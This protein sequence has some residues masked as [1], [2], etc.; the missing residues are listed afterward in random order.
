MDSLNYYDIN[1]EGESAYTAKIGWQLGFSQEMYNFGYIE[2]FKTAADELVEQPMP[3][4]YVYPIMFSY[5]QFIELSL[6]NI[7]CKYLSQDEYIKFIKKSSH[8]LVSIWKEAKKL[9][10]QYEKFDE[11]HLNFIGK[12]VL[13]INSLDPAS[14]NFRY[15][16][17]KKMNNSLEK[18]YDINGSGQIKSLVI[19][20]YAVKKNVDEYDRMIHHTYDD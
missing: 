5:R 9:L 12:L 14:F 6:K 8:N 20:L 7:C 16:Q 17:D 11:R 2:S 18:F 19:N 3:D 10:S 15:P 1:A 4:L 13:D